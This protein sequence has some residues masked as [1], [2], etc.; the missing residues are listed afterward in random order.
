MSSALADSRRLG[1]AA[2]RDYRPPPSPR[3]N[4][5]SRLTSADGSAPA[6]PAP[7]E[8]YAHALA[9]QSIYALRLIGGWDELVRDAIGHGGGTNT[10]SKHGDNQ[11]HRV[12][13]NYI[14]SVGKGV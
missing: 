13:P 12:I 2:S 3:R 4:R 1:G 8:L 11:F 14:G 5:A 6:V 7:T 10:G 9:G